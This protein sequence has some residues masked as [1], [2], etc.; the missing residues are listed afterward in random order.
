[1]STTQE[2]AID[3]AA[4]WAQGRPEEGREIRCVEQDGWWILSFLSPEG[5]PRL[6]GTILA[7]E[8]STGRM[9]AGSSSLPLDAVKD[10]AR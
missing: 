2:Q 4:G 3:M 10:R 9:G 7:V 6:G 8:Q 5:R 1:M